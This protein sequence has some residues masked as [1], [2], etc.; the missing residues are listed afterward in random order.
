MFSYVSGTKPDTPTTNPPTAA[1]SAPPGTR[2]ENNYCCE[3]SFF[4]LGLGNVK[5][6]HRKNDMRGV[7]YVFSD[8]FN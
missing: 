3:F 7:M 6:V 8:T 5:Y 2:K 4:H 1:T